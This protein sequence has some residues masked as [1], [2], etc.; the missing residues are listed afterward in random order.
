MNGL[1]HCLIKDEKDFFFS[2]LMLMIQSS[3]NFSQVTKAQLSWH[4]LNYNPIESLLF[5]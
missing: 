3:T 5:V 4:V 2:N 1:C